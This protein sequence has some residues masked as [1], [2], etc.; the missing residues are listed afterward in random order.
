MDFMKLK[1]FVSVARH[2]NF[3]KAATECHVA[4]TVISRQIANLEDELGV[5]LFYRDNK[6]VELTPIGSKFYNDAVFLIQY[7]KAMLERIRSNQYHFQG[8]LKI[9]VGPYESE[10][11]APVLNHFAEDNPTIEISCWKFSYDILP[12]RFNRGFVDV[13]ITTESCAASFRP[14]RLLSLYPASWNLMGHKDLSFWSAPNDLS[15]V[16]LI[17]QEDMLTDS[18]LRKCVYEDIQPKGFLKSNFYETQRI[19]ADAKLGLALTPSFCTCSTD[20]KSIPFP[21]NSC[22]PGFVAA[23]NP[24]NQNPAVQAF[25]TRLYQ[26]LK[27][28]RCPDQNH[29]AS[30]A[31]NK[32]GRTN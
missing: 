8:H 26:F 24:E 29:L 2:L 28:E 6:R 22:L 9:G 23:Y 17:V 11:I 30:C 10:L 19:M 5:K 31:K 4:Q 7:Q 20:E 32:K 13:A 21:A 25:C 1:Y 3:S 18:F 27:E 16:N 12:F 15:Q 14:V